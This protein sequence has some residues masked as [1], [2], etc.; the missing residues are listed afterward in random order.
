M[1]KRNIIIAAAIPVFL[2]GLYYNKI[3]E[4]YIIN[5][6][7]KDAV[8]GFFMIVI[9]SLIV[10]VI[11]LKDKIR[12]QRNTENYYEGQNSVLRNAVSELQNQNREQFS[13][14][15]KLTI[16]RENKEKQNPENKN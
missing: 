1:R 13:L 4:Y 7:S 16:E 5:F 12:M 2:I 11:Q 8:N 3:Q 10:Y 6:T 15:S 14:I 9:L